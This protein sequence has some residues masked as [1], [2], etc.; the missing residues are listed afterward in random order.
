MKQCTNCHLWK[1]RDRFTGHKYTRDGL[2]SWCRSCKTKAIAWS[3]LRARYNAHRVLR[4]E[5]A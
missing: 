1:P 5:D 2:Q 3:R 4:L